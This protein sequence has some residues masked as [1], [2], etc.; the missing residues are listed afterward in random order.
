MTAFQNFMSIIAALLPNPDR[1]RRLQAAIRG[2]HQIA[3]CPDWGAL[4]R[5]CETQPVSTGAPRPAK[6]AK[7]AV[8]AKTSDLAPSG[9]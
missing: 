6:S 1:L 9:F 4:H 3:S 5:L 8:P 2:R 7:P